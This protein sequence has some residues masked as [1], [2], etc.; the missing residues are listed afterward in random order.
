M[1]S[2]RFGAEEKSSWLFQTGVRHPKRELP[3]YANRDKVKLEALRLSNLEKI[4]V[5]RHLRRDFE[6]LLANEKCDGCCTI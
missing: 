4:L 5:S 3:I 6:V 1:F 2:G